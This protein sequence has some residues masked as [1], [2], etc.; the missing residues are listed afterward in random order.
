MC[1]F[2][3]VAQNIGFQKF[4]MADRETKK[5]IGILQYLQKGKWVFLDLEQCLYVCVTVL[6]KMHTQFA[7]NV[8]GTKVGLKKHIS[9][10]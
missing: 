8:Q 4:K 5:V 1:L 3:V 10:I 7:K 6:E 2:W 9:Q